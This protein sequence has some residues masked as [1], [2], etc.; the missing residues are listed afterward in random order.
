MTASTVNVSVTISPSGALGTG[1]GEVSTVNTPVVLAPG[2]GAVSPGEGVSIDT[3][4]VVSAGTGTTTGISE[5][6]DT[7]TSVTVTSGAGRGSSISTNIAS[8]NFPAIAPSGMTILLGNYPAHINAF[9]STENPALQG[10]AA[11]N[12]QLQLTYTNIRDIDAILFAYA[13]RASASG[14]F[15]LTLPLPPEVVA[16]VINTELQDLIRE[17]TP[18]V[19]TFNGGPS[20]ESVKPGRS[21]VTVRLVSELRIALS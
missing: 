2:E 17:P 5:G 12:A 20:I 4:V 8:V 16:G 7:E 18:A 14:I 10:N 11:I 15:P 13:W 9:R 6:S 19:W 21:T 3:P 1:V